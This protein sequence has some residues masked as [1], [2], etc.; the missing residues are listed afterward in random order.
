MS[1]ITK[2]KRVN[3]LTVPTKK[4]PDM[5]QITYTPK[6]LNHIVGKKFISMTKCTTNIDFNLVQLNI[7]SKHKIAY[8]ELISI[9]LEP[10]NNI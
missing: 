9:G 3:I 5:V 6:K 1:T 10:G 4:Y 2:Y 8:N 7:E